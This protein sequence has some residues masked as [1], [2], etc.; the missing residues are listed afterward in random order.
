MLDAAKQ[1]AMEAIDLSVARWCQFEGL[2]PSYLYLSTYCGIGIGC[3]GALVA[4][5]LFLG[6]IF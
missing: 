6:S 3:G 1:L 4:K 5:V 2:E